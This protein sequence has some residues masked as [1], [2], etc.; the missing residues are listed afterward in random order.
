MPYHEAHSCLATERRIFLA[1]R[2]L[3]KIPL[4][5]RR[6]LENELSV[7]SERLGSGLRSQTIPEEVL[8][9]N[10]LLQ[11]TA[12]DSETNDQGRRP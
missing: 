8:A 11:N 9:E 7:T 12:A 6:R 1:T 10:Q 4:T 2:D 3:A 5:I